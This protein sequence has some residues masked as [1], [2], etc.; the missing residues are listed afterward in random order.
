[1]E[2]AL[3]MSLFASIPAFAEETITVHVMAPA[4]WTEPGLWAWSAPDGTN[5]F[6]KWPGE[7]LLKDENNTG[8][9]YYQVPSWVNSLIVNEGKDGGAQTTDI[10]IE[11][12]ELWFTVTTKGDDGKY[13][14]DVVYEAPEGF[15]T[16]AASDTAAETTAAADVPKTGV[17]GTAALW[18]GLMGISGAGSLIFRR[19]KA[20]QN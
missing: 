5:A 20:F 18:A 7:K 15:K 16:A 8:W 2:F 13:A 3:T 1:M 17:I 9:F 10:S 6:T 4:E 11:S 19:K 14:A 12:K